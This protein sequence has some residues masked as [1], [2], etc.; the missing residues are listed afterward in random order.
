[1]LTDLLPVE[2]E[3]TL[4]AVD[5]WLREYVTRP[6]ADLGRTGPVCP[7]VE[8]SQRADSLE[9]RVR[10]LGPAPS[11]PLLAES[12]RCGLDEFAEVRWRGSNPT[13]WSLVLAFPDLPPDRFD[14][15]DEAHT[16]IKTETVLRGLMIGQFHDRCDE[17]AARNP[18]FRVSRSPVPVVAIRQMAVHDV[19]FLKDRRDWFEEYARRFGSRYRADGRGLDPQFVE[20]FAR[21]RADFGAEGCAQ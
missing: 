19:L 10:L 16:L 9:V 12:L 6:H 2:I 11:T 3:S 15:L 20:T 13:L 17:R 21:A 7:F 5:R 14:L 4:A 1:M 18:A 8:P